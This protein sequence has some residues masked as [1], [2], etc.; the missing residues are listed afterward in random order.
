M[1]KIGRILIYLILII[2][3]L[4]CLYPLI[5][6]IL[7][8]LK[9]QQELY[10]N[11]WGV[12]TALTLDNYMKALTEG[13]I[14]RY[15]LNSVIITGASV[16]ITVALSVSAA[17]GIVRLKWKMSKVVLSLFMLGMMLPAY[18]AIIPLYSIFIKMGI[19]NTYLAVIIPNVVFGLAMGVFI[20]SGFFSGVPRELE[21]SAIIDGCS[22]PKAFLSIIFPL[23]RSGTVTVT[24]ITFVN[25]W[26]ELLFSQIFLNDKNLMP[27]TVG[28]TEFKG[29]YGTDHVGMMAAIIITVIPAILLYTAFHDKI[30]DSM[31]AGAVKG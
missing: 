1:R 11:P 13:A 25:V 6:M 31:V 24:V 22:L 23:V 27:L 19:L 4:T 5:W 18:S 3:L 28:L 14:G 26:N 21:E 16:L 29:Q 2:F 20:M 30:V 7:S 12:S 10:T 17:Y 9:T 8:S 15:F